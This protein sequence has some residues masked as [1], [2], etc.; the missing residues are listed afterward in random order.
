MLQWMSLALNCAALFDDGMKD[1]ASAVDCLAQVTYCSIQSC[2][3]VQVTYELKHR[4]GQLAGPEQAPKNQG[5]AKVAHA[6]AVP[7]TSQIDRT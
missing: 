4:R 6:E 3:V 5:Y 1:C 7:E 2:M